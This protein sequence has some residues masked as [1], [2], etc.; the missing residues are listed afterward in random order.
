MGNMQIM[1][2]NFLRNFAPVFCLFMF[3]GCATVKTPYFEKAPRGLQGQDQDLYQQAFERQ[4]MGQVVDAIDLWKR[5]LEKNPNSFE[6]HNNLGMVYYV[7]DQLTNSIQEFESALALEPTN[8]KV[9][10]NLISSLK[11]QVTLSKESKDYES[12]IRNLNRVAEIAKLEQRETIGRD[13]EA[14]EDAIFDQVK[15]RDTL[16]EYELFLEQ[17]PDSPKNSD[18]AR[19]KIKELKER[20]ASIL[21]EGAM[22]ALPEIQESVPEPIQEPTPMTEGLETFLPPVMEEEPKIQ[23]EPAKD[24][25]SSPAPSRYYIHPELAPAPETMPTAKPEPP[26]VK[27]EPK[28][29]VIKKVKVMT[30]NNPLRVRSKPSKEG[31]IISRLKKGS[32]VPL[33]EEH[34]DW[35]LVEYAKGKTGWISRKF[36]KLME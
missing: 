6:A 16:E 27:N 30:R 17:Y 4:K 28:P 23:E 25:S 18:E 32:V 19:E 14:L 7:N 36:S 22:L 5:F 34:G 1:N 24:V 12:A 26:V 2:S 21:E 20:M 8:H 13:I 9:R 31:K 15:R 29:P 33:M 35:F 11:F 3:F 10:D